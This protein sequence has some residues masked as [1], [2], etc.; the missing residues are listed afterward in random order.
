M[1]GKPVLVET[2]ITRPSV[3]AFDAGVLVRLAGLDQTQL[4]T[5]CVRPSR[6]GFAAE[7]LAVFGPR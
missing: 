1:R 6:H 5:T 4:H 3:E 7:V 2:F